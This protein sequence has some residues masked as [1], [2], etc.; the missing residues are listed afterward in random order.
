MLFVP[1][2]I[3]CVA[4]SVAA[5]AD[6]PIGWASVDALGQNGVTGGAG[7]T[8]VTVT[9]YEQLKD[10]AWRAEPYVIQIQGTIAVTETECPVKS[11]KTIVGLPPDGTLAGAFVIRTNHNIVI[12]DLYF[13]DAPDDEIKILYSAHHVWVDHCDFQSS[14]DGIFDITR[15]S[16]YITV[17]WCRFHN[18]DK[19]MLIGH[20]NSNTV[21]AGKLGVTV[22]HNWFDGT[23]QRHPRV[24]FSRLVHAYNNYY[25][26]NTEYGVASTCQ[27][28]VLLE[29]NYFKNVPF[30][31]YSAS[32]YYDSDPGYLAERDNIFE[33][34]GPTRETNG[35][36]PEAST[37]Y[38]YT[39]DPAA[40]APSL[41]M[42]YAGPHKGTPAPPVPMRVSLAEVLYE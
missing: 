24:R 16:D 4:L 36:V 30:P 25:L 23:I 11:H 33:S 14:S 35:T 42:Q 40:E 5:A 15:E 20:S 19:T 29:G 37:F 28:Y 17:S 39:L 32:G 22:H 8:T 10:Y 2:L 1:F 3:L 6:S 18:H 26:G 38:S 13:R 9:A 7:G 12:R 21:D 27:A 41:V 31:F 34:C